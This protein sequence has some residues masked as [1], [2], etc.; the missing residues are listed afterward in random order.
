LPRQIISAS[1]S[2]FRS[3]RTEG[4]ATMAASS[5]NVVMNATSMIA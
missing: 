1:C 4:A 2:R 3:V 5:N